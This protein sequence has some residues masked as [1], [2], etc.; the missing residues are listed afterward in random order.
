MN[1]PVCPG[2]K[3]NKKQT[4]D[5]YYPL[6]NTAARTINTATWLEENVESSDMKAPA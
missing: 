5:K 6:K 3:N 4:T 1:K 2:N